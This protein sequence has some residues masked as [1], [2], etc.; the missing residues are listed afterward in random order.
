MISPLVHA[1][2]GTGKYVGMA[3]VGLAVVTGAFHHLIFG[4]NRVS[5]DDEEQASQLVEEKRV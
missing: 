5:K 2:K 4:A 3:A 1:W